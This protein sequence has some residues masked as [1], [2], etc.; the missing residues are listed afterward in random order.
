MKYI[1]IYIKK[2]FNCISICLRI[3]NQLHFLKQSL[4]IQNHHTLNLDHCTIQNLSNRNCC[5]KVKHHNHHHH[6]HHH[7]LY[8]CILHQGTWHASATVCTI[9]CLPT[10]T[11]VMPWTVVHQWFPLWDGQDFDTAEDRDEE[12]RDTISLLGCQGLPVAVMIV[13]GHKDRTQRG[14][15]QASVLC[16]FIL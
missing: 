15:S 3:L 10:E 7:H 9:S 16:I 12:H 8:L 13:K 2:S 6:Q 5:S 14:R 1:Y 11:D 4:Q